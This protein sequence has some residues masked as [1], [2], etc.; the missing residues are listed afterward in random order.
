M[1][2]IRGI[3]AANLT[4]TVEAGCVLQTVQE[5]AEQAGFLFP[6][7][8]AAEGSC[9]IGGNLA[10]NAGGTQVLRYG[11]ARELCLGLE[12]VTP[13]GEIWDGTSGL[14]KDNTG[15]DLRDLYDRQRR[16]AGRHHRRHPEAVPAAGGA[17]HRLGRRALAGAGGRACWAWRTGTWA[18]GLTGFEVMGRFALGLVA[19]HFPQLRVPFIDDDGR[20]PTACCWRTPTTNRKSMRARASR[21]CWKPPSRTAASAM[22]WWPRTWPRPRPAVARAREHPAGAGRRGP[23]HQARHLDRR[24]AHPGT[25]WPRPTPCC[26]RRSPAC[27]W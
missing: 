26:R 3:D 12:V 19:K 17:A 5:A 7:S 9:T 6:L 16:H 25:S 1:N 22:R 23:E 20:R 21:P 11:N 15:Y 14:R 18:P 2:A 10:T 8:L 24:V 13:Q 27:G 4:M